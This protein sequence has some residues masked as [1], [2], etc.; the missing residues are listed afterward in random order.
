VIIPILDSPLLF[1]LGPGRKYRGD[2]DRSLIAMSHGE[3][4]GKWETVVVRPAS[5]IEGGKPGAFVGMSS[6]WILREQL[7]AAMVEY[8]VNGSAKEIRNNAELK[9]LGERLLKEQEASE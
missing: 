2:M 1:F 7:G 9:E 6:A 5:V 8:G 4:K 3:L